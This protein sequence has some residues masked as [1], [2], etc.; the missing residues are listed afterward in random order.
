MNK[1][2][3]S[4]KRVRLRNTLIAL[5]L[6]LTVGIC[7]ALAFLTATDSEKNLFTVGN[8][9]IELTEPKWD[10][11]NPDGTLENIIPGQTIEKDP[12]LTNVGDNNSYVYLMVEVPKAFKTYVSSN[13]SLTEEYNHQLFSYEINDGWSLINSKVNDDESYNYYLYAY[14]TALIPESLDSEKTGSSATLF[15]EVVFSDVTSKL[16]DPATGEPLVNLDIKITGYAIQSDYYNSEASNTSEAWQLYVN[17]NNWNWPSNP[18]DLVTVTY[19]DTDD[20]MIYEDILEKGSALTLYFEPDLARTGYNFNWI[21]TDSGDVAQQNMIV[22][23]DK[24]LEASYTANGYSEEGSNFIVYQLIQNEDVYAELYP[25][26]TDEF[27]KEKIKQYDGFYLAVEDL[28]VN[29]PDYPTQPIDLVIP[30]QIT[31]ELPAGF[32]SGDEITINDSEG[33]IF[34]SEL[35]GDLEGGQE[36]TLPVLRVAANAFVE[37]TEVIKS[38]ILPDSI[39]RIGNAVIHGSD[40]LETVSLSYGITKIGNAA[41]SDNSALTTINFPSSMKTIG[42]ATFRNCTALEYVELPPALKTINN[43]T[44]SGCSKLNNVV[45]PD[46]V[47]SI[48]NNAFYGCTSLSDIT[49]SPNVTS[50]GSLAFHKCTS[51]AEIE[52]PDILVKIGD[53]AFSNCSVLETIDLP[54]SLTS[55]GTKA[56]KNCSALDGTAL[57]PIVV[58]AG[59]TTIPESAFENCSSLSNIKFEGNVTAINKNAFYGCSALTEIDIP[60]TVTVIGEAAFRKSGLT[61]VEVPDSVKT[62]GTNAFQNASAL[63]SVEL[64]DN[65]ETIG[66]SAF[67]G[68]KIMSTT[69]YEGNI[70]YF[71]DYAVASNTASSGAITVKDGTKAMIDNIF[72]GKVNITSVTLPSSVKTIPVNAFSGCT[73]LAEV[74]IPASITE[75]KDSAFLNCSALTTI[76]YGGTSAQWSSVVIGTENTAL[77]NATLNIQ[78]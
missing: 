6:V 28:D 9:D 11:N 10:E 16:V 41:F 8:V 7:G 42:T 17:Q 31:F 23:T 13:G 56:F 58:P 61:S 40:T 20:T 74:N 15:D 22:E 34:T 18:Y 51:L 57:K 4:D 33:T 39:I 66:V 30:S 64:G 35:T 29:H 27:I 2:L 43:L 75:I 67:S 14:N 45:I 73:S 68:T 59:I 50:I 60:E 55:L 5:M 65:I 69:S 54:A 71:G 21:D 63:A 46:S 19:N 70:K 78:G 47:T 38:I 12:T 24:V 77:D 36:Y 44:F 3:T 25:D 49:I 72:A 48:G 26:T 52:L 37:H 76:N 32:K 53:G 1:K 62:I